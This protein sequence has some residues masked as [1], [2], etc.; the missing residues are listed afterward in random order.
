MDQKRLKELAVR[1]LR[2]ELAEL[3][4]PVKRKIAPN[5]APRRTRRPMSEAQ[6]KAHS[7]RMKIYWAK[8][9]K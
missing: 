7:E 8:R 6:K 4:G 5:L 3:E 2:A 9:K 1:G